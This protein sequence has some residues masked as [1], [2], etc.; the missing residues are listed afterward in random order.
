MSMQHIIT[1]RQSAGESHCSEHTLWETLHKR[2]IAYSLGCLPTLFKIV[3][4]EHVD[5]VLGMQAMNLLADA[6]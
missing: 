5:I 2:Q 4:T 1:Q 3:T 6:N